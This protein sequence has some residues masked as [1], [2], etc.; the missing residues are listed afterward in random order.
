MSDEPGPRFGCA[1][2]ENLP[3]SPHCARCSRPLQAYYFEV[4]GTIV[5]EACG[6]AIEA[7]SAGRSG[8]GRAARAIA[9]GAAAAVL[10]ALLYYAIAVLT[11][12]QFGLMAI[13]VG[14]GVGAAVRWGSSAR[15][16]WRYQALAMA[17]TYLAMVGIYTPPIASAARGGTAQAVMTESSAD[18]APPA[19]SAAIVA[20]TIAAPFVAGFQNIIGVIIIGI[21]LYEAWKLNT[22]TAMTLTGPHAL[23]AAVRV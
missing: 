4:N 5:C 9:T 3:A 20:N 14:Y 22:R 7:E 23:V 2:F 19:G 18:P 1:E 16:G 12:Y 17:L 10:G 15:G 11:G 13:V 6:H 8:A 21:G